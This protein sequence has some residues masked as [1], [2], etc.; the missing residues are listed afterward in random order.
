MCAII[1]KIKNKLMLICHPLF[2][3]VFIL[4]VVIQCKT[5]KQRRL[6][7]IYAINSFN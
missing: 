7:D 6:F 5:Q 4:K 2:K 1:F 3:T